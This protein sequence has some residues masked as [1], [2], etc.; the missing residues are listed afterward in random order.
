MWLY[1]MKSVSFRIAF[2][3]LFKEGDLTS[4][5]NCQMNQLGDKV[6]G[7]KVNQYRP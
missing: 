5:I 1:F 2:K 4:R 7:V 3:E 6:G